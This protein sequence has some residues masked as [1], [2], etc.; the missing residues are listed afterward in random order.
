MLEISCVFKI[1]KQLPFEIL[2]YG[3]R[4]SWSRGFVQGEEVRFETSG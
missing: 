2:T 3:S 4:K 1:F